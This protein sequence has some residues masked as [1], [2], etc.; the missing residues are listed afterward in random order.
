MTR[1][2]DEKTDE[3]LDCARVILQGKSIGFTTEE[4]GRMRWGEVMDYLITANELAEEREKARKE[5]AQE[6]P[7]ASLM[8]L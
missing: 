8:D 2:Q 7:R 6:E 5:R 3:D 4:V 1:A